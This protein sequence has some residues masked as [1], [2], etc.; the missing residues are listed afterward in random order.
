MNKQEKS[1]KKIVEILLLGVLVQAI[2]GDE[3]QRLVIDTHL[4]V[5]KFHMEN[6]IQTLKDMGFGNRDELEKL[7]Q[8]L[9]I[10]DIHER[11]DEF[12]KTYPWLGLGWADNNEEI[13]NVIPGVHWFSYASMYERLVNNRYEELAHITARISKLI[14]DIIP[15]PQ[16]L[17]DAGSTTFRCLQYPKSRLVLNAQEIITNNLFVAQWLQMDA[18][19][20]AK[21]TLIGGQPDHT[22]GAIIN[23]DRIG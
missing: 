9:T 13:I 4:L 8:Y 21:P 10:E 1:R 15:R 19:G 22:T 11:I 3:R 14:L 2:N 23:V 20:I 6:L 17:V 7:K 12:I 16:L 5:I 18:H